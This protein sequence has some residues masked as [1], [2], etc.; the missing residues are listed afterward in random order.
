MVSVCTNSW[1]FLR[2]LN[3]L[4]NEA[5]ISDYRTCSTVSYV[6][7]QSPETKIREYF[8]YI[9]HQGMVGVSTFLIF[10]NFNINLCYILDN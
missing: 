10:S 8:Y 2:R 4:K 1:C 7:G 3:Y 9:D 6:Q 5:Y